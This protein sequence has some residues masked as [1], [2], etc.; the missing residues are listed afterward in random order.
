M[1]NALKSL[2]RSLRSL[3]SRP[4]L[5]GEF[6]SSEILFENRDSTLRLTVAGAGALYVNVSRPLGQSGKSK[7]YLRLFLAVLP[8]QSTFDVN[9]PVGQVVKVRAVGLGGTVTALFSES[10]TA[11]IKAE[12]APHVYPIEIDFL[13]VPRL[14]LTATAV[15]SLRNQP[16]PICFRDNRLG[17]SYGGAKVATFVVAPLLV[18][19]RP[20][21]LD[22]RQIICRACSP[23]VSVGQ[24]ELKSLKQRHRMVSIFMD[25]DPVVC[26]N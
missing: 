10:A 7:R 18:G 24:I 8:D 16:L 22:A 2:I 3:V 6:R 11:Q 1:Q 9:V 5:S 20:P 19:T 12:L 26:A 4:S 25:L 14:G 21:R 17:S 15:A 23:N 13:G